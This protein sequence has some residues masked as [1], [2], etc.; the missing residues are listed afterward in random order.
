LPDPT[1]SAEPTTAFQTVAFVK[2]DQKPPDLTMRTHGLWAHSQKDIEIPARAD[3]ARCASL[4]VS[5]KRRDARRGFVVSDIDVLA[6]CVMRLVPAGR[7]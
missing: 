6:G 2:F 3:G 4:A 5:P 1:F 7:R